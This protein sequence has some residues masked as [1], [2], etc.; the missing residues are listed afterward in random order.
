MT[1]Q[2]E[3]IDFRQR[4][5]ATLAE[6]PAVT[7]EYPA[8]LPENA[9]QNNTS[10]SRLYG[11]L[12]DGL[13]LSPRSFQLIYP[14]MSW[15]WPVA[16]VGYTGAAQYNFC[17]TSPLFSATGAYVSS[18]VT[19][20]DS[21]KQ[22]LNVV[23]ADTTDPALEQQIV[24]ARN[25]LTL[26]TNEYSQ[27]YQQVQI[28]YTRQTGGTN[29]PTFETW[30]GGP[31]ALSWRTQLDGLA[32]VVAARQ[33]VLD[34]LLSETQT[35]G[36]N[37]AKDRY[38]NKDYYTKFQDSTLA[39]FPEVPGYSLSQD[40][41]TWLQRVKAGGGMAG[42]ISVQNSSAA[43]DYSR[44]W[45]GGSAS[46]GTFF[47]SVNVGGSWERID[48]FG[49][50]NSLEA[51][52]SFKAWDQ[53]AIQAGRWYNG[54]FVTS[55]ENGPFIR[56]YSPYGGDEGKAVWGK[57]GIMAAQKVGMIVCYKPSFNI[58]VSAQSF[59][60]FSQKWDA[61]AGLRIG[62]FEFKGSGGSTTS[63]WKKDAASSTFSGTSTGEG[64][65]ILGSTIA[66][67]NPAE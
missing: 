37:D 22:M 11:A 61:C 19:F 14:F 23:K 47:W 34:Q 16:N 6:I 46:V 21:Y 15:D 17:S 50:D 64:A 20:N 30:L 10:W 12:I 48:E 43:Y 25:L 32:Q 39:K 9:D 58:R 56:G 65:Q 1:Q 54:A 13:G 45:A 7:M 60:S 18:G 52:V 24:E 44:T 63:G 4:N 40:A 62:P 31:G 49:S 28:E 29:T 41:T 55:V 36:L 59:S 3:R 57:E 66:L 42:E 38:N 67:I 51:T 2:L 8:A 53:I 26:A 27:T 35:P 5:L 33:R